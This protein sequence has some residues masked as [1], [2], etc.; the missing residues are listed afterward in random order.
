MG[1]RQSSISF[2]ATSED[3]RSLLASIEAKAELQDVTCGLFASITAIQKNN[4][5]PLS[6]PAANSADTSMGPSKTPESTHR[7]PKRAR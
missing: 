3:L 7:F 2:F 6:P 1:K 4:N 5:D